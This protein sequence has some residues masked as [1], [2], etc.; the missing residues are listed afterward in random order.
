M[1]DI[2][3][4]LDDSEA[5][6][7]RIRTAISLAGKHD[8][9]VAGVALMIKSTIADYISE[10][11]PAGFHEAQRE[12]VET[13]A[14]KAIDRFVEAAEEAGISYST[15]TIHKS[16]AKIPNALAFHARH[17]D[18]TI[19]GQVDHKRSGKNFNTALME[20]A[21]F[22]SGRPVYLVPYV[23]KKIQPVKT[24]VIA[25]DG[26]AKAARSVNDAIPLLQDREEIII[27]VI[28]ADERKGAHGK[29]PGSDI[30]AHLAHYNVNAKV[31]RMTVTDIDIDRA[32]LNFL[33]D[34]G[35]DLLVMGAYGHSRL[36]EKAFGGVTN[37][38]LK[39]MT[40]PVLMSN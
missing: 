25:W 29:K 23:G 3:V 20:A 11:L 32:I 22:E 1:K 2:L 10:A 7:H 35:A 19:L 36:R 33:A 24:A 15:D 30:A 21:L 16:A 6:T 18:I 27:L 14:K 31:E 28:N 5:C 12:A 4:H 8:A 13:S 39:E 26:S 9:H 40:T 37:N 38:I 34:S 17:T